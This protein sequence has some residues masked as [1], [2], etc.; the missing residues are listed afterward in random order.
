MYCV[1]VYVFVHG[2]SKQSR[3][4]ET[5]SQQGKKLI[6]VPMDEIE[7][8]P[9]CPACESTVLFIYITLDYHG[10]LQLALYII[11]FETI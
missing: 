1:S 6:G 10:I 5:T 3:K 9:S 2:E 4:R 11:V 7:P 8:T